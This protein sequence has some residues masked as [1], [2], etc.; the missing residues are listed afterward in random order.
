MDYC[1][2]LLLYTIVLYYWRALH[3]YICIV[4]RYCYTLLLNTIVIHY[5]YTLLLNTI[6]RHYCYT[7]LLCTIVI[8]I[9][10]YTIVIRY[11]IHYC[12]T[13][14]SYTIFIHY[15]IHYCYTVWSNISLYKPNYLILF[16]TR[17]KRTISFCGDILLF[18]S[19]M[20]TPISTQF[21]IYL[22]TIC[23]HINLTRHKSAVFIGLL[24]YYSRNL[25]VDIS[26]RFREKYKM[27]CF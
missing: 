14:L 24:F 5:C 7:L 3:I 25:Y 11:F 16:V 20:P 9:L 17:T 22:M 12:Y 4:I 1:Y 26:N 23:S 21:Y 13:L 27:K 19:H 15:F 6:V 2:T 18:L 8:H 10:L